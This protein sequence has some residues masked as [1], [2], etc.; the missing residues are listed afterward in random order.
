[1][2]SS[3]R[4]ATVL[5]YECR[6]VVSC[7]ATREP[8]PACHVRSTHQPNRMIK[9]SSALHRSSCRWWITCWLWLRDFAM[10]RLFS[11][12]QIRS[13]CPRPKLIQVTITIT[14]VKTEEIK[15]LYKINL[16]Q[17]FI[18][19]MYSF[20]TTF[21]SPQMLK[22]SSCHNLLS[23][24]FPDACH[25]VAGQSCLSERFSMGGQ[26]CW[27]YLLETKKTTFFY[28]TFNRKM[29]NSKIQGDKASPATLST[30]MKAA[31]WF[32]QV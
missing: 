26:K 22:S 12:I 7:S 30:P 5:S 10:G 11:S 17:Q 29:S 28:C 4:S 21:F 16:A 18:R 9:T 25:K 2:S 20:R 3:T 32:C 13:T 14:R 8:I 23:A 1:M 31:F 6:A 24:P 15:L 27:N 19:E